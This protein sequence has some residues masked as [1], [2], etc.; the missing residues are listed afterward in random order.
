MTTKT[1]D[2]RSTTPATDYTGH[3][4]HLKDQNTIKAF[5]KKHNLTE[6]EFAKVLG[7]RYPTVVNWA[8]SIGKKGACRPPN[9]V[10]LCLKWMPLSH[11]KKVL[12]R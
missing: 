11:I 8:R 5:C 2:K 10:L 3:T 7:V 12:S 4:K 6:R 9:P 1:Q